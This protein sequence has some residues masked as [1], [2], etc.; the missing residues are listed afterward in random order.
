MPLPSILGMTH[1]LHSSQ[2][3]VGMHARYQDAAACEWLVSVGPVLVAA[4]NSASWLEM[5]FNNQY[6]GRSM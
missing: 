3:T 4:I 5:N 1:L 6:A 2:F